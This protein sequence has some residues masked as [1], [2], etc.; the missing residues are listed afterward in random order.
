MHTKYELVG[1]WF[2]TIC[3]VCIVINPSKSSNAPPF[4]SGGSRPP[5]TS[6]RTWRP[7]G[8]S[9]TCPRDSRRCS[10]CRSRKEGREERRPTL[11]RRLGQFDGRFASANV[12]LIGRCRL[13]SPQNA[14]YAYG[15][16]P[17]I[18][19]MQIIEYMYMCNCVL[20]VEPRNHNTSST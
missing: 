11:F 18:I 17:C 2:N 10:R 6:A 13:L 14:V 7:P 20:T 16:M 3:V 12:S 8:T 1:Y 19:F 15:C 9:C 5:R 4:I